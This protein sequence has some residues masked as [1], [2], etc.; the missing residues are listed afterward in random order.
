MLHLGQQQYD[1]VSLRQNVGICEGN[2]CVTD[3]KATGLSFRL[4]VCRIAPNLRLLLSH[5]IKR[6]KMQTDAAL[7]YAKPKNTDTKK[8]L[9]AKTAKKPLQSSECAKAK[10]VF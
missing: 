1:F 7:S 6:C 3:Y 8:P 9:T 5:L 4:K 2:E 10:Q